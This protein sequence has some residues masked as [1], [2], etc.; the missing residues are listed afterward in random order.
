[1]SASPPHER[2]GKADRT[3]TKGVGRAD[4]V[5]PCGGAPP[6][7]G[8]ART[9]LAVD[10]R[11]G[12]AHHPGTLVDHAPKAASR[13]HPRPRTR[14]GLL[15]RP[16][17]PPNPQW[18]LGHAAAGCVRRAGESVRPRT[19]GFDNP[20]RPGAGQDCSGSGGQWTR[21]VRQ[22]SGRSIPAPTTRGDASC[23]PGE[24]G[25]GRSAYAWKSARRRRRHPCGRARV[26]SHDRARATDVD[27]GA[28]RRGC[29]AQRGVCRST[30]GR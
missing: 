11:C 13:L 25:G 6:R 2:P 16:D 9:S 4:M 23:R 10:N 17:Q 5:H 27:E 19:R 21:H 1:M 26:A 15:S 12:V 3:V 14:S 7:P 29:V 30:H 28:P 22:R 24:P 8:A 20:A 18:R